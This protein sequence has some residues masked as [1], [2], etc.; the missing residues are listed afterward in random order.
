M[1]TLT[2][3]ME[4]G[5][6]NIDAQHRELC[7]RIN[8]VLTAGASAVTQKETENT[9]RFLCEYVNQHFA[10]EEKLQ[11]ECNYPNFNEHRGLHQSFIAT[12]KQLQND[13]AINGPSAKFTLLINQ[14]V[15][16]W[17]VKHIRNVDM[18]F[19]KYYLNAKA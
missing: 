9:L 4:T 8:A 16:D 17:L 1:I 11:R 14:L 3:D 2:K 15:I 12:L 5:I 10:D 19:A 6:P 18:I 7:Q 13:F